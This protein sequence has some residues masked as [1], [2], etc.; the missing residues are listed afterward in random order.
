MRDM[1][2][3]ERDEAHRPLGLDRAD[4]LDDA[5]GREPQAALAQRLDGD[6]VAVPGFARHPRGHDEFASRRALLDRERASRTVRREAIDGERARLQLVEDLD[7]PAGIS[8]RFRASVGVELDPHQHPRANARGRGP[9]PLG[10]G[11]AHEN[12]RRVPFA[13]PFHRLGDQF[14]VAGELGYVGDDERGQPALDGQRLAAARDGA[15]GLQILDEELQFRFRLALHAEGA[16]DVALGDP[17]GR[18]LAVG[19]RRAADEGHDLL[20]RRERG[21]F[22][23]HGAMSGACRAPTVFFDFARVPFLKGRQ[24]ARP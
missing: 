24:K 12:A 9:V 2:G 23:L 3:L 1:M 8:G 7:H 5:R 14:A 19:R 16:G 22:W 13:A 11:A 6:E 4:G 20:A 15:F 18:P 10:A 21:G 17:R